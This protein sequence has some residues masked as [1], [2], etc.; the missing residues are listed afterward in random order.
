MT[1]SLNLLWAFPVQGAMN[2]STMRVVL[3]SLGSPSS[4][5]L[6]VQGPF[7]ISGEDIPLASGSRYTLTRRGDSII[8]ADDETEWDLGSHCM[9]ERQ[10][11]AY[12]TGLRVCNTAYGWCHYLGN[13]E[14]RIAEEGLWF[15]NHIYLEQYL[16]GVIPYEMSGAW[17]LE[18]LKS[19]AVAARTYAVRCK[20]PSADYDLGDTI[21]NQIYKG[22][23]S[24]KARCIQA[25]D[26]TAG[27]VVAWHDAF[28]GTYYTASNGGRVQSAANHWGNSLPY[29]QVKE[30]PYDARS[31]QNPHRVWSVAYNRLSVDP[32]LEARLMPHIREPLDA[33]GYRDNTEDI[34]IVQIKSINADTPDES[35]R[36][37]ALSISL[38][39]EAKKRQGGE[40]QTVEQPLELGSGDIQSVLGVKS[41]LFTLQTTED[42]CIFQGAGY[43]HGIG[44]SQYGARQMADEGMTSDDILAFYYPGT[45]VKTLALNP[46]ET[47]GE[48]T[49]EDTSIDTV[50]VADTGDTN[51]EE[52]RY[53]TVDV[54]TSLNVRQGPGLQYQK[55]GI[56]P[57]GTRVRILL[58]QEEWTQVQAGDL[59][60]Y[61]YTA[62]VKPDAAAEQA[63][64]P[65]PNEQEQPPTEDAVPPP[66]KERQRGIVTASAL[67]VRSGPSTKN[68]QMGL[69]VRGDRVEI[70]GRQGNW[71]QI[72]FADTQGYLYSQ[73]I[74]I[75][76]PGE[77]E[78]ITG[79]GIITATWLNVRGGP[80]IQYP[81]TSRLQQGAQVEIVAAEGSWYQIRYDGQTG[82]AY[83]GYVSRI[84]ETQ[85][86]E[87]RQVLSGTIGVPRVNVRSAPTLWS[88]RM[89]SLDK[90][91]TIQILG[92]ENGWYFF[93]YQ[94]AQAY[95]HAS[96]VTI[97]DRETARVTA[98]SL[99]IRS[100]PGTLHPVAGSLRRGSTVAVLSE[101]GDWTRILQGDGTGYVYSAYLDKLS[102]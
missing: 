2:Y 84:P 98:S 26:E 90:G 32:E 35:G 50:P 73:H 63:P 27:Q 19:Q 45:D 93:E 86:G 102:G 16:Y 66:N 62:Y 57:D 34:D 3:S 46:P 70:T 81:R 41:L 17:P 85:D 72:E 40:V 94:G 79:T 77:E 74:R 47:A 39:V 5:S 82:Y 33:R 87:S 8:L 10:D 95:V 99:N 68:H 52:D 28:A 25:V 64:T 88:Q 37:H 51:A 83:G 12:D 80:G 48:C 97:A 38:V 30:D 100:G 54:T 18:A 91:D 42:Q 23:D 29:S 13:M 22:Y 65:E 14:V 31:T 92:A 69:Y 6:I 53:G 1:V 21:S 43:G 7:T 96:M 9:F 20:N 44:M 56:L 49:G 76:P 60:G 11:G 71:Y 101:E 59:T 78:T 24:S 4:L 36:H 15:I 89:G 58:S 67:Y 55:T 61:V 75:V